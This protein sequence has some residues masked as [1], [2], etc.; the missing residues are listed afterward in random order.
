[1]FLLEAF[2]TAGLVLL[3][4]FLAVD[5][6]R[7]TF[8]APLVIG[9]YVFSALIAAIPFTNASLN[10]AR[11]FGAAL[12]SGDWSA[13][14]LFWLAPLTGA[15]MAAGVYHVFKHFDYE[16]LNPGQEDDHPAHSVLLP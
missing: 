14:W 3:V 4:L 1:G 2:L 9:L 5:K 15:S 12:V 13:H 11:T 10:P 16:S 6:S 7:A 8:L